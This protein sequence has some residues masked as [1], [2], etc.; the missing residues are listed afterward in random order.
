M[1]TIK[2]QSVTLLHCV[3]ALWTHQHGIAP[4]ERSHLPAV[5]NLQLILGFRVKKVNG[6][7]LHAI[8]QTKQ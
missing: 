1:F 5:C 3:G 7:Q 2:Q 4:G 8:V 6:N